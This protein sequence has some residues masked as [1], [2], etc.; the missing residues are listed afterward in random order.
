MLA[1]CVTLVVVFVVGWL[2]LKG[3]GWMLLSAE[4]EAK[5]KEGGQVGK[6]RRRAGRR[7]PSGRSGGSRKDIV[8]LVG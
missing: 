8:V 5:W 7:R 3:V 4:S 2:V 1:N 6:E